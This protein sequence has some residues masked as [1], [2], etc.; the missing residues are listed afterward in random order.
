MWKSLVKRMDFFYVSGR[1]LQMRD[2]TRGKII[3]SIMMT[4]AAMK[5]QSAFSTFNLQAV[6]S[7]SQERLVESLKQGFNIW[8]LSTPSK[9]NNAII[10]MQHYLLDK[11]FGPKFLQNLIALWQSGFLYANDRTRPTLQLVYQRASSEAGQYKNI[12]FQ[13]DHKSKILPQSWSERF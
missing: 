4:T 3:G 6:R 2:E 8:M 7:R 1:H 13:Q 11:G 10:I 9:N 12:I 5:Y